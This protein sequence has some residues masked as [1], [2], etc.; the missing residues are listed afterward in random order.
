MEIRKLARLE[1]ESSNALFD[2]LSDWEQQLK[3]A[4]FKVRG[5]IV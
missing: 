5:P 3:H 1:L 4:D 2:T